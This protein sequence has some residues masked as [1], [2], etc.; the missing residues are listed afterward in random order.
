MH[1][2]IS[3]VTSFG[4]TYTRLDARAH[5]ALGASA[6]VEWTIS[7]GDTSKARHGLSTLDGAAFEAWG[8]D[9]GYVLTWLAAQ[10]NLTGVKIGHDPVPAPFV[11]SNDVPISSPD[12]MSAPVEEPEAVVVVEEPTP[13]PVVEELAVA[14]LEA[15]AKAPA[16]E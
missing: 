13:A 9:D 1:A 14:P 4:S 16:V 2:T 10:L 11:P 7:C 5:V 3:P 8:G 6:S 15:E 12:G